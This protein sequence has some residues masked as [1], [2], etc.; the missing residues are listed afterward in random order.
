VV[1]VSMD[2][3]LAWTAATVVAVAIYTYLRGR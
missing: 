3:V 2:D 1:Q